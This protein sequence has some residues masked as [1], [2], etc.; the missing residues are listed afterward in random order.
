MFLSSWT[1]GV[2]GTGPGAG[3]VIV[4]PGTLIGAGVTGCSGWPLSTCPTPGTSNETRQ[5]ALAIEVLASNATII[6]QETARK[7][8]VMAVKG[9]SPSS[10]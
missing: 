8:L 5:Q 7:Y 6:P 10:G 9:F 3:G 2:D 4:P 1:L